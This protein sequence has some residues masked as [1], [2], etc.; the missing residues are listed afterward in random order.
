MWKLIKIVI[1]EVKAYWK[2]LGYSIKYK[3]SQIKAIE[4]DGKDVDERC[5]MLL[6]NWLD[7][8]YG[9]T[10]KTWGKLIERISDVD[11]LYA[12]AERIQEK[13]LEGN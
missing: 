10:P 11:E 9:C 3:T 7:T 12:A 8:P 5:I 1:P 2:K 6:E 4:K 13:L